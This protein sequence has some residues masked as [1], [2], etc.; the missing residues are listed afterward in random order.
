[1]VGRAGGGRRGSV[2]AEP[3]RILIYQYFILKLRL[4]INTKILIMT[5]KMLIVDRDL[6]IL[7]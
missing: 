3:P 5:K 2:H 1:M 6:I 7:E 4:K